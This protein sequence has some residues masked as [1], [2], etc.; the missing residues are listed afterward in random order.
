MDQLIQ[1]VTEKAGI[2]GDSAQI[3][4]KTVM[5]FLEDKL[6]EP[7]AAQ[8]KAALAGGDLGDIGDK[9]SGALGGLGGLF[10]K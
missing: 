6:P 8:I 4:I 2:S 5:S 7:I 9:V 3:A 10:G 1:L